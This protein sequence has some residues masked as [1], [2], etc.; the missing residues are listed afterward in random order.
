MTPVSDFPHVDFDLSFEV[1][2]DLAAARLIDGTVGA[3]DLVERATIFDDY[4][5]PES[6]LRAVAIR[7][8]LRAQDRT[9]SGDEVAAERG[10]MIERATA[11]GAALR[12][13]GA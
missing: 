9:L 5:D 4:R 10:K 3:S 6:G 12:G 11:L 13:G 2:L 1:A 7:Y 8:R